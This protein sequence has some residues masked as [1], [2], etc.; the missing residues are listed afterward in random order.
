LTRDDWLSAA[1]DEEIAATIR[2]GKNRMPAFP[3]L[4]DAVLQGLV[5]RIRAKGRPAPA[6]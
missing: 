2:Q 3:D 1:K 4:P 5:K 6:P